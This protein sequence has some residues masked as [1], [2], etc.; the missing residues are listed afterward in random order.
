MLKYQDDIIKLVDKKIKSSKLK[1]QKKPNHHVT[2]DE[3]AKPSENPEYKHNIM[4]PTYRRTD[5]EGAI[6]IKPGELPQFDISVLELDI[7]NSL[8]NRKTHKTKNQSREMRSKQINEQLQCMMETDL[9]IF[10]TLT[11]NR[12]IEIADAIKKKEE[13]PV[14]GKRTHQS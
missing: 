10:Q 5:E 9:S 4:L 6:T 13:T 2:F 3:N 8:L 12:Q 1:S 7:P 11:G 14:L